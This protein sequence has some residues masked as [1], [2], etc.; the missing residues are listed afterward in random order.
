MRKITRVSTVAIVAATLTGMTLSGCTT[1]VPE[2][3]YSFK[4]SI[5]GDPLVPLSPDR[6]VSEVAKQ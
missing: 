4:H 3:P 5:F 6:E 1:A 2:Q